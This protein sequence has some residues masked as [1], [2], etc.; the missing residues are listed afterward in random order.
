MI[1]RIVSSGNTE[2]LKKGLF[3]AFF[4]YA[5]KKRLQKI[6]VVAYGQIHGDYML[7]KVFNFGKCP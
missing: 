5:E 7:N 3:K 4:V 1:S 2:V 6:S